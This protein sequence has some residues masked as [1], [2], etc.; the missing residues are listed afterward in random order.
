MA[1]R[2]AR[3]WIFRRRGLAIAVT[4]AIT[5]LVAPAAVVHATPGA[6]VQATP[7]VA[8]P[9]SAKFS[10]AGQVTRIPL[11][12][13]PVTPAVDAAGNIFTTDQSR[14]R[15]VK[16]TPAGVIST[17]RRMR[18]RSLLG[19][20][21]TA[22][23]A[24]GNVYLA[25]A[26]DGSVVELRTD[27]S[28]VTL[29][30]TGLQLPQSVAVDTHGDV[31]VGDY[32][33]Q[34]LEIPKG[35]SQVTLP[36][37]GLG[38][39]NLVS[40]DA[41]GDV[42]DV[43]ASN[44]RVL[45]IPK[46]G[47][48]ITVGFTGLNSPTNV[49]VDTS[50]DL[51]VY[52]SGN[53]RVLELPPGGVQVTVAFGT[54]PSGFGMLG[55][56]PT[57]TLY[58][59]DADGTRVIERPKTGPQRVLDLSGLRLPIGVAAQADGSVA[60][61]DPNQGNLGGDRVVGLSAGG[62]RSTLGFTG[63]MSPEDVAFDNAGDAFVTDDGHHRVL[64]LPKG[65]AQ[66]VVGLTGLAGP[67]GVFIDDA[68]DVFVSDATNNDVVELPK[69]GTQKTLAFSGLRGPEGV[70]V[71]HLGD[72]FV[73]DSGN[74]R[75]LELPKGGPQKVLG[76]T[77]L[78]GP[79]GL[80]LDPNGTVYVADTG[81]RRIV[82]LPPGGAATTVPFTGLTQP[83]GVAADAKGDLFATDFG[84]GLVEL[85]APVQVSVAPAHVVR[86]SS[87]TAPL[88]F[89]VS[90]GHASAQAVSV[91]FSTSDGTAI[92]LVDYTPTSG[93]ATIPAR[94]TSTTVSVPVIGN[95]SDE[96]AKT[97]SLALSAPTNAV[98]GTATALGTIAP[99]HLL[100]GCP[101]SPTA[102]QRYVCHIYWDA[103]SRQ[104]ETGGFNYWVNQL[105]RG[106]SRVD[107]ATSYLSQPESRRVLVD[108]LYVF[109]L[110]RHGDTAGVNFW[111]DKLLHG[112]TPDDI[113]VFLA[114]SGEF[115]ANAG[116]TNS[117]FVTHLF[118]NVFRRP[119]D[120]SGL[121]YWTGQLDHGVSRASVVNS[122]LFSSEGRS[123]IVGDIFLRFL[124]RYPT[125]AEANALVA[126]LKA[127]TTEIAIYDQTVAGTEYYQRP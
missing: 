27:G 25:T 53:H 105:D 51:F 87:G 40:V 49:V 64:E 22:V 48:Q 121:A 52:D 65:G 100:A 97:F 118:A 5:A 67:A 110:G 59:S 50:G 36:F 102:N 80:A 12:V 84:L 115:W 106:A 46:G 83:Y 47:S 4:Y 74:N 88:S 21:G 95:Q 10:P 57:D 38:Y 96:P 14:G 19:A 23:D 70:A 109:F 90:L 29:P 13:H 63:L 58:V 62:S 98:V 112:A 3:G 85:P 79:T 16:V 111:A 107:M 113:R 37:S 125:T 9:V 39:A 78:S 122:F 34:V 75:V 119:V 17:I 61:A 8:R 82:E 117:G 101:P 54:L 28:E 116:G 91:H 15:V 43:D 31:F 108:R 123:H 44:N 69:G 30:F 94:Q 68:G 114:T 72:V 71:D 92:G 93:T 7:E 18:P 124:R 6:V 86:P 33:H 2:G 24:Q 60:V 73:V 55:I 35:G 56:G 77:G 20:A 89:T 26:G 42:F 103:L 45:E 126:Q 66:T 1:A 41:A 76:F 81:N 104:A 99:N 120:S 32:G 11:E 127:G